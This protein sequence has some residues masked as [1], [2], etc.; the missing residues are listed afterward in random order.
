MQIKLSKAQW[1]EAG[2]KAGWMKKANIWDNPDSAAPAPAPAKKQSIPNENLLDGYA[3]K[4][5][6]PPVGQQLVPGAARNAE[7]AKLA[8][9]IKALSEKLSPNIKQEVAGI[10][11]QF[12]SAMDK[13]FYKQE[14]EATMPK[15]R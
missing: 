5:V 6:A 9:S 4:P 7:V 10:T 14:Q 12:I 15:F 2:K 3:P 8:F 11:G 1:E 13:A